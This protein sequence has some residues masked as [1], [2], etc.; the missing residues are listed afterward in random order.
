MLRTLNL[1]K[2]DRTCHIFAELFAISRNMHPT[3][4]VLRGSQ[5]ISPL[6]ATHQSDVLCF[7]G[8]RL[9][10]QK[11]ARVP[12]QIGH[13]AQHQVYIQFGRL[14]LVS[15]LDVYTFLYMFVANSP[16]P[17]VQ[18]SHNLNFLASPFITSIVVPYIIPYINPLK[19]FSLWLK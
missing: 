14:Q 8:Q 11:V 3:V 13:T 1:L 5:N 6:R 12:V 19:E 7:Q 9:H 18:V 15:L 4:P 17:S 2:V 10:I 16:R